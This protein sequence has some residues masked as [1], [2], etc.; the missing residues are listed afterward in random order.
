MYYVVT[1]LLLALASQ[2][3]FAQDEG[4]P[5]HLEAGG[6]N[7]HEVTATNLAE[8]TENRWTLIEFYSPICGMYWT[9]YVEVF[10]VFFFQ[11][12]NKGVISPT[13]SWF[14]FCIWDV[15]EVWGF[16]KFPG[17]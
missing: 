6:V 16:G 9:Q 17:V 4:P 11:W 5:P 2:Q 13:F 14:G 15:R 12:N 3:S 7:I 1:F 10:A 8:Y